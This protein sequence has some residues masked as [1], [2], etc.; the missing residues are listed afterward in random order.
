MCI[1]FVSQYSVV[2]PVF[3]N[4]KIARECL[5][6]V[7]K[8]TPADTQILVIDDASTEGFFS[9][10]NIEATKQLTIIR[11]EKNLGFVEV[12]NEA[13]EFTIPSDVILVNSDVM[14]TK[15]WSEGYI[16]IHIDLITLQL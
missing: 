3:N 15:N 13:F 1:E 9:D 5:T 6:N 16:R 8:N 4:F 11:K 2:I 7:L 10:Y 12:C 14:V